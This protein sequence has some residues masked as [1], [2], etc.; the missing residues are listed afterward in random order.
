[1]TWL[2]MFLQH[3]ID[4]HISAANSSNRNGD[5]ALIFVNNI[6]VEEALNSF[7]S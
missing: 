2:T 3:D 6:G 5:R 1:M 4:N 7:I